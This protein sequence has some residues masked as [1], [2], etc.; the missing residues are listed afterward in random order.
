M[1][2]IIAPYWSQSHPCPTAYAKDL[3]RH[4]QLTLFVNTYS[5]RISSQ[6]HQRSSAITYLLGYNSRTVLSYII[7]IA[8]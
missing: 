1:L 2:G 4:V 5:S 6:R 3:V 8:S 7:Y